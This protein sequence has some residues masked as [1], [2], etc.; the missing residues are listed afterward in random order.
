MLEGW[1][2]TNTILSGWTTALDWYS[3]QWSNCT[4]YSEAKEIYHKISKEPDHF[5]IWWHFG[6]WCFREDLKR[7]CIE[8][9]RVWN[10]SK[11]VCVL[12][13]NSSYLTCS[14]KLH[15]THAHFL[16]KKKEGRGYFAGFIW[17]VY[18]IQVFS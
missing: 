5:I 8:N 1:G 7:L 4:S 18:H 17:V 13:E 6:W 3:Q 11:Y 15:F 16:S 9:K 14:E 10:G 12:S 2:G